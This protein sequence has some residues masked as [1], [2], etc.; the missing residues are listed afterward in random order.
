MS[1]ACSCRSLG[2]RRER[3]KKALLPACVFPWLSEKAAEERAH[4]NGKEG[5]LSCSSKVRVGAGEPQC[6]RCRGLCL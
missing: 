2:S 3:R 1:S 5:A 4:F 6:W